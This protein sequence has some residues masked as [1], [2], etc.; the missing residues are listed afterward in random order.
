M[1]RTPILLDTDIGSNIDDAYALVLA[2]MSPELDLRGVTTVNH[3]PL[4]RAAIA[5]RVLTYL[6]KADIPIV[7]GEANA[8][9][10]STPAGWYGFEG[11]GLNLAPF[12]PPKWE[13]AQFISGALTSFHRPTMVAIGPMTNVALALREMSGADR[14][15]V[16]VVAMGGCADAPMRETNTAADPSAVAE[17]LASGCSI[18]FVPI[19]VTRRALMSAEQLRVLKNLGKPLGTMLANMHERFLSA[20]GRTETA[21]HDALAVLA[22]ARPKLV[23]FVPSHAEALVDDHI[24]SFGTGEPNCRVATGFN[25]PAFQDLFWRR[26]LASCDGKRVI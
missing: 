3:D 18:D 21:M 9:D 2:A 8:L 11:E 10:G 24:V 12:Q 23:R 14:S 7:P 16:K 17:I 15:R 6:G 20:T 4:L 22:V 19:N 13:V 26:I 5:M 1:K 25:Q